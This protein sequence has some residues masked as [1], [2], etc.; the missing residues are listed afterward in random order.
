MTAFADFVVH[1]PGLLPGAAAAAAEAPTL[2]IDLRVAFG[3]RRRVLLPATDAGVGEFADT[4]HRLGGE[5]L[6]LELSYAVG[7]QVT[8]DRSELRPLAVDVLRLLRAHQKRLRADTLESLTALDRAARQAFEHDLTLAA[9]HLQPGKFGITTDDGG[10]AVVIDDEPGR[11]RYLGLRRWL[12]MLDG[13]RR[14]VRAWSFTIPAN[15]QR[16]RRDFEASVLGPY[17]GTMQ[18]ACTAA[19]GLTA[20][21]PKLVERLGKEFRRDVLAWGDDAGVA[22]PLDRMVCEQVVAAYTALQERQPGFRSGVLKACD[23]T[24]STARQLVEQYWTEPLALVFGRRHP[25]WRHPFLVQAAIEQMG[26]GPGDRAYADAMDALAAADDARTGEQAE[27]VEVQRV[28]GW[29]SLGFGALALVPVVG[30][31]AIAATIVV[32]AVQTWGEAERYLGTREARSA[33]GGRA[34]QYAVPEPDALGLLCNLLSLTADVA[35][36]C[37][38]KLL[39]RSVVTPARQ[40]LS[41]ANVRKTVGLGQHSANLT[42][43]VLSVSAMKV[44]QELERVGLLPAGGR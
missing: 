13:L 33:L 5:A 3:E 2:P 43:L 4:C 29:A 24:R 15:A 1:E 14:E 16:A 27:A 30:E 34:E 28:L 31:L 17:L 40:A 39:T 18:Q 38:G 21:A 41:A 22:G 11:E 44:E 10:G 19:P 36:P 8:A 6:V 9:V 7:A 25:L 12:V 37:L 32:T 20:L 35:L 23:E 26:W 42:A